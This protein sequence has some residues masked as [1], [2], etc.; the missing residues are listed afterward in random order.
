MQ[1]KKYLR[2][3]PKRTACLMLAAL[4]TLSTALTGCGTADITS[5]AL[6]DGQ[7]Y[8]MAEMV[9]KDTVSVRETLSDGLDANLMKQASDMSDS[10]WEGDVP[11]DETAVL[12]EYAVNEKA[13]NVPEYKT[14]TSVDIDDVQA[15]T[16]EPDYDENGLR[17]TAFELK[18]VY[19]TVDAAYLETETITDMWNENYDAFIS[20]HTVM[21]HL[22]EVDGQDDCYVAFVNYSSLND[23]AGTIKDAVFTRGT[24][25]NPIDMGD[26]VVL[27]KETGI[28]YVPKSMYF[29]GDGTEAGLDLSAQVMVAVDL[30]NDEMTD[31]D[32][33]LLANVSVTMENEAGI[34]TILQTGKY[35]MIAYDYAVLPLFAPGSVENLYS[36][37]IEVFINGSTEAL[38]VDDLAYNPEEGKLTINKAAMTISEV[39]IVLKEKTPIKPGEPEIKIETLDKSHTGMVPIYN[40]D[41]KKPLM[42]DINFEKLTV[43][44]VFAYETIGTYGSQFG[45]T[46]QQMWDAGASEFVYTSNWESGTS[47][48]DAYWAFVGNLEPDASKLDF[49]AGKKDDDGFIMELPFPDER[50]TA[51]EPVMIKTR[52]HKIKLGVPVYFGEKDDWKWNNQE[53][54]NEVEF[55]YSIPGQ[56]SY[57]ESTDYTDEWIDVTSGI[58]ASATCRVL[59][60][61]DDY[62]ILG[63]AQLDADANQRGTSVIK[64]GRFMKTSVLKTAASDL[65]GAIEDNECYADPKTAE[66]GIYEDAEAT[67]LVGTVKADGE[68]IIGVARGTYYLKE[69]KAPTGYHLDT[70]I[71]EVEINKDMTIDVTDAPI[72]DTSAIALQK[73]TA[74][75]DTAGVTAGDVG[76]LEGILFDVYFF[77]GVHED[78]ATLPSLDKADAHAVFKTDKDGLLHLDKDSLTEGSWAYTDESGELVYPLGSVYVKENTPIDGLLIANEDG[79]L[80]TLTDGSDK[81]ASDPA[82][83]GDLTLK[84]GSS[85]KE[86]TAERVAGSYENA[87]AKGTVS[88]TKADLDT[89]KSTPQGDATLEGAEFTI[90]N[91]SAADI[92][93]KGSLVKP[94]EAV[95]TIKTVYDEASQ[96]YVASMEANVLEYGTYEIKETKAPEGYNLADWSR[97][98]TIRKDGEIHH[99]N[100]ESKADTADETGLN[101]THEQC[102]DDVIRGGIII[103]KRDRETGSYTALG[104][105][106]LA[107]AKFKIVNKSQHPVIVDG[108]SYDPDATV[109]E[110][111]AEE[112][113]VDGAAIVAAVTAD[114]A[115]PY[116]TYEVTEIGTGTGYLFDSK[117]KA[118]VQTVLIREDGKMEQLTDAEDAFNNQVQREDWYFSKKAA[119][120]GKEMKNVAWTVTSVTT[121]EV[122]VIVTDENGKYQSDQ[123]KHTENTNANDPLSPIANGAVEIDEDG[124]YYV[125]DESKLDCDAGTWFTGVDPEKTAWAEDGKSYTLAGSTDKISVNDQ[126]RAYPYDTYLVQELASEANKGY[127]LVSFLVTLNRYGDDPDG[128]GI[129]LDY[130][131]VTNQ[132]VDIHTVLTYKADRF[133]TPVKKAPA[134]KDTP[135]TAALTYTGLTAGGTYTA[136]IAIHAVDT[137]GNDLGV[138]A[139]MS[140]DFTAKASG[141][142]EFTINADTTDR[143]GQV[144][145]A[146]VDLKQG[147]TSLA[148]TEGLDDTDRSVLVDDV[149]GPEEPG[150]PDEPKPSAYVIDSYVA[151]AEG[152][153]KDMQAADGQSVQAAYRIDGLVEDGSYKLESVLY[154]I[155]KDGTACEVKDGDGNLIKAVTEGPNAEGVLTFTG[156]N[157]SAFAGDDLI[158][159]HTL[160]EQDGDAWK[161]AAELCDSKNENL[162][163]HIPSI[164]TKLGLKDGKPVDVVTYGN[165]IK[166]QEYTLTGNL[167][168]REDEKTD[169]GYKAVDKGELEG[170]QV[171]ASFVAEAADGSTEVAFDADT[172]GLTGKVIVA[173]EELSTNASHVV[174]E[175]WAGLIQNGTTATPSNAVPARIVAVHKDIADPM[176]TASVV[177]IVSTTLTA[178]DGSHEA[179][180]SGEVILTDTVSYAGAVIGKTYTMEGTLNVKG[181]SGEKAVIKTEKVTFKPESVSGTVDVKF[182][183]KADELA[184][185]TVVAFE[186][187]TADGKELSAH[188]DINDEAQSVRFTGTSSVELDTVLHKTAEKKEDQL[189]TIEFRAMSGKVENV[190]LTDEISFKGL[191]PGKTYKLVSELHLKDAEGK[192][193]AKRETSFTPESADGTLEVN[194]VLAPIGIKSSEFVAFE[195]IYDG[196]TLVASHADINDA[197][198]TVK[199]VRVEVEAEKNACGCTDASCKNKDTKDACTKAGCCEKEG[200]CTKC[201]ECKPKATAS[202]STK[203]TT[204]KQTSTSKTTETE[205]K[206]GDKTE[207]VKT[208]ENTFLFAGIIGLTLASGGGYFFFAKT[209]K[210]RKFFKKLCGFFKRA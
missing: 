9:S 2:H 145:T 95:D 201:K 210:G 116:G 50:K 48:S 185:K 195:Y 42:P 102:A 168:I 24:E 71:H 35:S 123:A 188:K 92:F 147:K 118:Q 166:G 149:K 111:T 65:N 8:E 156:I 108:T 36:H 171:T 179:N 20:S 68:D 113:E 180:A 128:N 32:G 75:R 77:K 61:T 70:S 141:Q 150:K 31:E 202:T 81:T 43:G 106:E 83:Q 135:L 163:I 85:D 10:Y 18:V 11:A 82:Y 115:L 34:D 137:E 51:A 57:A 158:V 64:V 40:V 103:G 164:T 133:E 72:V 4:M 143:Q 52:S 193:S 192:S 160:Y 74:D 189:K 19:T 78:I 94:G 208:G 96:S 176:Q 98:F 45:E 174:P 1:N 127:N 27:D 99:F 37:E 21:E 177:T 182:V 130:G 184:G 107:G 175:A 140:K 120:S 122:H 54:T 119:D 181:E 204:K 90:Y 132:H 200:C 165:L 47:R 205:K 69:T 80:F 23:V 30:D 153:A 101:Q 16:A 155:D 148:K 139:E 194:L 76:P 197:D 53:N 28:L 173:F 167:H 112:T 159:Y 170:S 97:T 134:G 84:A 186:T 22:Y 152:A 100:Q 142:V 203:D 162:M 7:N 117:S 121:G 13:A 89:D 199:V 146:V 3:L 131:T 86:L 44:D 79:L 126:M 38:G 73:N 15:K 49:T 125:A 110:I 178:P 191:T 161:I 5:H 55:G 29:A 109:M 66:Y 59:V 206:L 154:R 41:T 172:A 25:R 39:R 12:Y 14:G 46:C 26:Q 88:V 138:V 63:L 124:T 196:D 67:K 114:D 87:V 136:D 190:K 183:V 105:A 91:R 198:Q 62:V 93:Y 33:N 6:E 60:L 144:L 207:S 169:E 157:A 187:L 104:N 58:D 209:S 151:N 129:L 17:E 56:C